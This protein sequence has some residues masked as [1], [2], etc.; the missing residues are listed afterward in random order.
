MGIKY[1]SLD[2]YNQVIDMDIINSSSLDHGFF[3]TAENCKQEDG[4]KC[5]VFSLLMM[6]MRSKG[7]IRQIQRAYTEDDLME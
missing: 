2:G 1:T 7:N 6:M 4:Y 3:K 5:G